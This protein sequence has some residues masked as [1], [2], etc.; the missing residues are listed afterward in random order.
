MSDHAAH[1]V[2]PTSDDLLGQDAIKASVREAYRAVIGKASSA[3]ERLYDPDQLRLLPRGAIEQA[4]GVG[5][6]VRAAGLHPGEVVIDVGCGGGIDT[7]LAAHAVAPTGKAIGLD[8]LP[9]MLEL[10]ARHAAEAGVTNVEWLR[11]EME[12]IPLPDASVDVVI[13]NG[14]VN[15]SPRKSRAFA[16]IFR[17]LRPGGRMV[18]ADIIVDEDLPPEILTNAAAWAG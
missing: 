16:E 10:A 15:L 18:I 2:A 5:N 17:V 12:A 7:I 11:G 4:L 8:M 1:P 3:A 13:S 9:E 14:V 6:P